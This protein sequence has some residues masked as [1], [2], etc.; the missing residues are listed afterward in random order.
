MVI[1]AM[2][3]GDSCH[4][5]IFVSTLITACTVLLGRIWDQHQLCMRN[6]FLSG[7][8]GGCN[9]MDFADKEKM[10]RLPVFDV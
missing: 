9:V 1:L 5:D 10:R 6:R 2:F 8:S 7:C 4:V 3:H